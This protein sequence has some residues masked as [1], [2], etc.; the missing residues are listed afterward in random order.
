MIVERT[1]IVCRTKKDKSSMIRIVLDKSGEIKVEKGKK[2][3]GRGAYICN[4]AS[5][6]DKF[7]KTKS[8]N[9]TFKRNFS[10]QVYQNLLDEIK[11]A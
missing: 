5:C 9:R 3:D 6:L 2:L 7:L 4:D 11:K 8:L 1:C 10:E